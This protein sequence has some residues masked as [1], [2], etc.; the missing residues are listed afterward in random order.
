MQ[1]NSNRN[2]KLTADVG[3]YLYFFISSQ[4]VETS[5]YDVKKN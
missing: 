2:E 3:T 1:E 5:D 4:V